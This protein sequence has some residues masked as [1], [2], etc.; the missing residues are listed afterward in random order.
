MK[1]PS[2]WDNS[3][4][5]KK[6]K[7]GVTVDNSETLMKTD[8]AKTSSSKLTCA[9]VERRTGEDLA[10]FQAEL[11]LTYN[12][13]K[14][15]KA[16]YLSA[17]KCH[18]CTQFEPMI[19]NRPRF[20]RAF[21]DPSTSFRLTNGIDHAKSEIHNIAFSLYNKQ[22]GETSLTVEHNQQKLDFNLTHNRL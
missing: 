6:S 19:K 5:V 22:K 10:D 13:K 8:S 20:S 15:G 1:S 3:A 11:W 12:R 2:Y 18:V 14:T 21:I 4:S 16:N 17:L 9:T 7:L